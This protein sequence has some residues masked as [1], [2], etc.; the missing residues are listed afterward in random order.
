MMGYRGH[1][2]WRDMSEYVVHFVRGDAAGNTGYGPVMGILSAGEIW[3]TGPFGA[4]R[5]LAD[6]LD[7]T[8]FSACF[9]EIPLDLLDRLVERR[10]T[11]YGIGFHQRFIIESGGAR[12]WYLDQGSPTSEAM[13]EQIRRSMVGGIDQ[14]NPLWKLT[15]FVDYPSDDPVNYRFEWEREWRVP[16]GLRF[17][18]GDVAFLLMPEELHGAARAFFAQAQ[19]EYL[20]PAYFCPYLD[21]SWD[22]A[23]IQ[24]A[25]ANVYRTTDPTRRGV[26]S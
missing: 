26:C 23:H 18:P 19:A 8:Q 13:R 11:R 1:P 5:N 7:Q 10:Q 25:V 6:K 14:D 12:V 9:S 3:G 4:A 20:G 16:G 22:D 15:P 17:L 2:E 24:P 21:P